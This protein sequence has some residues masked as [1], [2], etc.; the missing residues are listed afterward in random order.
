MAVYKRIKFE[1]PN[2]DDKIDIEVW[3]GGNTWIKLS[4]LWNKV[5]NKP[6]P[7]ESGPKFYT[8]NGSLKAI[9]S[10]GNEYALNKEDINLVWGK[11]RGNNDWYQPID[12]N[13]EEVGCS[14]E[15]V[16]TVGF[17]SEYVDC[18]ICGIKKEEV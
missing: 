15:W 14:H 1:E 6:V 16:T 8:K 4:E 13:N 17:S 9:D 12:Y 7:I 10:D 2:H 11:W 5:Y 18:A 3:Q